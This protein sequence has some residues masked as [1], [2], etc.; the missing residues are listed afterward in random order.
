MEL[1][2][3]TE[4]CVCK[5]VQAV[6][7]GQARAE[8]ACVEVFMEDGWW[9]AE[10]LTAGKD[11]CSVRVVASGQE[12]AVRAADMR[13]RVRWAGGSALPSDV[14]AWEVSTLPALAAGEH[15]AASVLRSH[16][17]HVIVM[18]PRL[19]LSTAWVDGG[20]LDVLLSANALGCMCCSGHTL[21]GRTTASLSAVPKKKRGRPPK[22]AGEAKEVEQAEEPK[23]KQPKK[24]RRAASPDTGGGSK[25]AKPAMASYTVPQVGIDTPPARQQLLSSSLSGPAGL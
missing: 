1:R 5:R 14:T 7:R 22:Q 11:G 15:L 10:V 8:G 6:Q 12:H 3:C 19:G 2:M 18:Q 16:Q 9:E 23:H 20:A 17:Q 21:R 24:R 4:H 13:L 25:Q